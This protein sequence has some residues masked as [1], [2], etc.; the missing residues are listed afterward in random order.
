MN[1][2]EY[3][4]MNQEFEVAILINDLNKDEIIKSVLKLNND[5]DFYNHFKSQS[6]QAK[7]KWNWDIEKK[8]LIDI[9]E[10]L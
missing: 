10:R 4:K 9:Y 2:P 7:V 3:Q 8:T 5:L 1:F 6:L